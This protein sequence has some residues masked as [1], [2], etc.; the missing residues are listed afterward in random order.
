MVNDQYPTAPNSPYNTPA[1]APAAPEQS[2]LEQLDACPSCHTKASL[3]IE[4]SADGKWHAAC[5]K[6]GIQAAG[7]DSQELAADE[8][9]KVERIQLPTDVA[10][11]LILP[12]AKVLVTDED[13]GEKHFETV[14]SIDEDGFMY[15][16][17]E[18]GIFYTNEKAAQVIDDSWERLIADIQSG[19]Q[20]AEGA[21][22]AHELAAEWADRA[23]QLSELQ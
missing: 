21:V 19:I 20:S 11:K 12:G 22:P 3:G 18:G 1:P 10:G 13:G 6:C 7:A 17:P 5:S 23:K 2:P 4:R 9:N 15:V 8:W 16:T 14:R